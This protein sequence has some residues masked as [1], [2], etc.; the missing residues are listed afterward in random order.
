VEEGVVDE[1]VVDGLLQAGAVLVCQV[2]GDGDG[3]VE[4]VDAGGVGDFVGGDGNAGAGGGEALFLEIG[5]GVVGGAGAEGGEQEFGRG[6]AFVEAA[7]VFGLI[8]GDGVV[9]GLDFELDCA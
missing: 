1:A 6:H 8:A 5:D 2:D 4:V 9:A 7:H 3:D